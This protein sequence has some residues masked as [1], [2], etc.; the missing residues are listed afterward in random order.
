M[1][2]I[3]LRGLHVYVNGTATMKIKLGGLITVAN[4]SGPI[5]D[6][7]ETVT[8]FNDMCLIAPETLIDT[9]IRWQ[10]NSEETVD[11]SMN[12]NS[13]TIQARL[14]VDNEGDLVN[15]TSDDRSMSSDGKNYVNARWS[16]PC[17]QHTVHNGR[18]LPRYGE[19]CW[20]LPSGSLSYARFNITRF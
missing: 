3:P 10:E 6:R 9:A 7:G 4:A 5:M 13:I 1:F 11:A 19:A 14:Y 17:S 8:F 18:R 15:F 16:T 20:D 12:V 2:G